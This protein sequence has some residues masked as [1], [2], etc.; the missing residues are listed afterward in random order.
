M[1]NRGGRQRLTATRAVCGNER[2][3][4]RRKP[5]LQRSKELLLLWR[6]KNPPEGEESTVSEKNKDN[7]GVFGPDGH[8][9][10]EAENKRRAQ[11]QS[12][13]PERQSSPQP[14]ARQSVSAAPPIHRSAG[15]RTI[16]ER[17]R[18]AKSR[19]RTP[20]IGIVLAA[21]AVITV[22][23]FLLLNYF[24]GDSLRGRWDLD[25]VTVYR[26]D[27]RGGGSLELPENSYPFSYKI[28]EGGLE[29][30]FES[31]NARDVTYAFTVEGKK[32]TLVK[33][34]KNREITYEL[35]KK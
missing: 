13:L 8:L 15:R 35:T 26:F 21:V 12:R 3:L 34:E 24:G 16:P 6:E 32:L 29:I 19:R 2:R 5:S 17:G 23:V 11:I 28:G 27:G 4:S 22:S 33:L 18:R 7:D 1:V 31:E 20:I 30:D 25:G 14:I 9:R 10:R